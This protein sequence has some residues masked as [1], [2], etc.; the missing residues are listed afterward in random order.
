MLTEIKRLWGNIARPA[1]DPDLLRAQCASLSHQIPLMYFILIVASWVLAANFYHLAPVWLTLAVPAALTVAFLVRLLFWARPKTAIGGTD[2]IPAMLGRTNQ[3]AAVLGAVIFI[4]AAALFPYGDPFL[5]GH[6]TFFLALSAIS[7]MFCLVQARFAAMTVAAVAVIGALILMIGSGNATIVAMGFN[8]VLSVMAAG[9]L[10]TIQG[11]DFEAMVRAQVSARAREEE[12]RR[13]L[14]MVDDMPIAVMTVDPESFAITYA[15]ETSIRTFRQIQ[16]L[17]PIRAEELVGTRI[18]ALHSIPGRARDTLSNPDCLPHHTRIRIGTEVL[19]LR[20]T[21]VH[22]EDESF[23]GPMLAWAIVTKEVEAEQH[24]RWLAHHDTLTKLPNRARFGGQLDKVLN[25]INSPLALLFVDLDGF[26]LVNDT[27]GHAVGD[28]VLTQVAARLLD[29]CAMPSAH[30]GRLGGDEF[31]VI[32]PFA[33]CG[34][35]DRFCATLIERL[36]SP[37]HLDDL[38]RVEIGASIGIALAPLHGKRSKELLSRA[39][40]ALSVAKASGKRSFRRFEPEME[41][42]VQERVALESELR[43]ALRRKSGLFVFYQPILDIASGR[44]TAREALVR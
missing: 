19:D 44:V 42:Q 39:D 20:V 11:R 43:E 29:V 9:V 5:Q 21:A 27:M 32:L 17:L 23:I 26:K 40:I 28:E 7:T 36:S 33:D 25:A 15:N 30:M 3:V 1:S 37:Y 13:L 16:H 41:R 22:G 4:W 6:V 14:R 24:I 34:E 18:D 35:V 2:A 10:V 8:I 31:A 12:Q 38:R